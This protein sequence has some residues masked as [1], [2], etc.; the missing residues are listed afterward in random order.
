MAARQDAVLSGVYAAAYPASNAIDGNMNGASISTYGT[1][2]WLS[3][4]VP[5]AAPIGYV[6]I[7]NWRSNYAYLMGNV[8]VWLGNSAGD[9]GAGAT[10]C[11]ETRYD[12]SHEPAPYVLWCG[13]LSGHRYVTVKRVGPGGGYIVVAELEAFAS[14]LSPPPVPGHQLGLGTLTLGLRDLASSKLGFWNLGFG[15]R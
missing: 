7:H 3:V 10:M 15:L 11:G 1:R 8:Q 13:G 9:T 14:S 2:P 4:Q 5:A 6:A 12:A